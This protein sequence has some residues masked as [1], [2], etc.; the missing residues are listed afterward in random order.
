M[1]GSF[2]PARTTKLCLA[3]QRTLISVGLR[4]RLSWQGPMVHWPFAAS[5]AAISS[6]LTSGSKSS[7]LVV[8]AAAFAWLYVLAWIL[9][10]GG[11]QAVREAIQLLRVVTAGLP[12]A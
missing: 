3:H 12:R 11:R 4:F 10:P 9:L 8:D 2:H 7:G 6:P 5:A 1:A